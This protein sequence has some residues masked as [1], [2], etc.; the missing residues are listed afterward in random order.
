MGPCT[1]ATRTRT[2]RRARRGRRGSARRP[3]RT[4]TRTPRGSS[5]DCARRA[6]PDPSPWTRASR[7]AACPLP[8]TNRPARNSGSHP[9]SAPTAATSPP[10]TAEPY[11]SCSPGRRPRWRMRPDSHWDMNAVPIVVVAVARPAHD[12]LDPSMSCRTNAPTVIADA[13]ERAAP[14]TCPPM[15][16]RRARRCSTDRSSAESGLTNGRRWR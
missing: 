6:W 13:V 1:G 7:F 2:R 12:V 14:T 8:Y 3:P 4:W 15:S 10:T 16:T 11:P 5:P 9:V